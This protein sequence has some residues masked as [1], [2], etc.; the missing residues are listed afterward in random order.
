MWVKSAKP[1]LLDH[2]LAWQL[3][4]NN[5]INFIDR[6]EPVENFGFTILF[7]G[8]IMIEKKEKAIE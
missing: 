1:A 5:S 2:S 4:F 6:I 8:E 3:V 7:P